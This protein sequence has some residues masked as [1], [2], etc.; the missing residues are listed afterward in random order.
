MPEEEINIDDALRRLIGDPGAPIIRV[1]DK[2]SRADITR[3]LKANP[4]DWQPELSLRAYL[5]IGRAPDPKFVTSEILQH[6]LTAS[7]CATFAHMLVVRHSQLDADPALS[8]L[9]VLIRRDQ[10]LRIDQLASVLV[11][12][13][14]KWHAQR[15]RAGL[16]A[17]SLQAYIE[18]ILLLLGRARQHKPASRVKRDAMLFKLIYFALLEAAEINS[19]ALHRGVIKLLVAAQA[20]I[21]MEIENALEDQPEFQSAYERIVAAL[22]ENV[23][24]I[25]ISG[26]EDEFKS[27]AQE[28]LRLR[29]TERRMRDL[30]YGLNSDRGQLNSRVQIA[31]SELLGLKHEAQ[32]EPDFESVSAPSVQSMQLASA[33]MRSWAAASDS[34]PAREAFD[35]LSSVMGSF[36]SL[37]V[38]G[39]RGQVAEYNPLIHE[40][41][42]SREVKP[43]L[44]RVLRPRIEISSNAVT[45]VVIKALV[46]PA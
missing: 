31:L 34:P 30:L 3:W 33:L 44:V 8:A 1:T 21:D 2:R 42:P 22:I 15:K 39:E 35:E 23:R 4:N 41:S 40:V 17:P 43:T 24:S 10:H 32:S 12:H 14:A 16:D 7:D 11:R 27:S 45:R 18:V 38:R 36:F 46:E 13:T 5:A 25:A 6:A 9:V 28:L 20:V 19:F 37:H 26:I 29:L